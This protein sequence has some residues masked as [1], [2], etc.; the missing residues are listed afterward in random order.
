MQCGVE[1]RATGKANG[2]TREFEP[3]K[4][5]GPKERCAHALAERQGAE[6][7]ARWAVDLMD[8]CDG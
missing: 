5:E 4:G 2:L 6:G 3:Q 8:L 7:D 1:H